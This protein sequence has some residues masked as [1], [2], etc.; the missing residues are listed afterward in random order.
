MIVAPLWVVL[1]IVAIAGVI[2]I[3]EQ[4][5]RRRKRQRTRSAS[6]RWTDTAARALTR[7][8]FR[9]GP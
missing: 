1:I 9:T 8:S 5:K 4:P 6:R 7:A 3:V 2:W